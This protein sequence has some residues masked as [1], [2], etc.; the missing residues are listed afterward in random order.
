M[1]LLPLNAHAQNS[2]PASASLSCETPI[3]K[4]ATH[5]TLQTAFGASN[6]T[7]EEVAGAEG[8]TNK[9]TVLFAKNPARRLEVSWS[10]EAK[11]ARPSS[12]TVPPSSGWTG[13]LGLHTGMSLEDVARINGEPLTINGF[14]WD[15][16]GY[17][18]DLKGRLAQFP[19]GCGVM[20]RFSPGQDLQPPA[21][22]KA[23]VGEK[24]LRSDNA[25]LLSVKPKLSGWSIAFDE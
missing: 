8:E 13:P 11:R 24:K 25:L 20:L 16:G 19:G 15:Y 7:S 4:D 12:I 5:A 1:V 6:V 2:Q 22:Y 18:V 9:V 14:E 21:K 17:A 23:L 10:N 3:G